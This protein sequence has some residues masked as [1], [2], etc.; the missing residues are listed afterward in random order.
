MAK[1]ILIIED[2]EFLSQLISK[3]I[4]E[5]GF[6]V[7]LAI[8]GEDGIKKIE[9]GMPDLILLDLLLPKIDGFEV[10]SRIKSDPATSPIP[11]VILSNLGKEEEINK[12]LKLGA[13]DYLVKAQLTPEEIVEK[14]KSV[15]K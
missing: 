8:D 4:S 6:A 7:S 10:L 12:G 3:K 1:K 15:L 14:I 11:V 5:E 9:K 13:T 2:D